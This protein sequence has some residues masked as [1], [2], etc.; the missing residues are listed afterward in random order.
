[1]QSL[2]ASCSSAASTSRAWAAA[3]RSASPPF[4]PSSRHVAFSSSPSSSSYPS[5]SHGCRWPVAPLG[6]RGVLRPL[7]SPLFAPGVAWAGAAVRTRAAAT[8]ASPAAAAE[9]GGAAGISRA[10]QLGTMILVWYLLNIYF[11][12]YNKL[13]RR[14]APFL[15][16]TGLF[17]MGLFNRIE[18]SN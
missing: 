4:L 13:V 6:N 12:I 11:N 3:R 8:K 18:S 10:L 9:P 7:P 14:C 2:A 17:V 16:L 5:S 15:T 1:M